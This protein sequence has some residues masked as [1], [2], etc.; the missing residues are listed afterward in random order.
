MFTGTIKTYKADKGFG[1]IQPDDGAADVFFHVTK[2]HRNSVPPA[3]GDRVEF[4]I[5]AKLRDGKAAPAVNIRRLG[6]VTPDSPA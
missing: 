5:G 2:V 3:V 6:P 4:E 1:F